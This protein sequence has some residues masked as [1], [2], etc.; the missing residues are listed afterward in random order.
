MV[1]SSHAEAIERDWFAR[2]SLSIPINAHSKAR[3]IQMGFRLSKIYTRT[4]D[5]GTTGLG[6]GSRVEK[7]NP[8]VE[9]YG[10]LDELNSMIGFLLA[11]AVPEEL[12]KIL[13]EV[14]HDLLDLGGELSIPGYRILQESRVTALEECL[15][16]LNSE[17]EPLEDFLLPGGTSEAGICH[18]A[19]T[20]CRR[21]ERRLVSLSHQEEI[22]PAGIAYINR[23][24]DLLFVMARTLNRRA[25]RRDVLWNRSRA[26]E[27]SE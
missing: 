17:L 21:A 26:S 1:E 13:S 7:D 20:V 23:L 24:S 27:K 2:S 10:D 25:G 12:E 4:G 22:N 3:M 18:L 9:S 11:Q 16:R 6:D 14:Q 5:Q 19:R 15:D 8:R